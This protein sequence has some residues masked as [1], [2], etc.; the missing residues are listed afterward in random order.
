MNGYYTMTLNP[1]VFLITVTLTVSFLKTYKSRYFCH[2]CDR[3]KQFQLKN[4]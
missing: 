1:N 4:S 2:S 3:F